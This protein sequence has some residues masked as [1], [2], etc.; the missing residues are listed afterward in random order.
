MRDM[1]SFPGQTRQEAHWHQ[2]WPGVVPNLLHTGG[3]SPTGILVY[4]GDLL[5]E[6]FRG[7]LIHCDAGPNVVRAYITTPSQHVARGI[8]NNDGDESALDKPGAG[9]KAESVDLI[10]AGDSWFRPSDACV[11]PDGAVYIADWYDPGVGGHATGDI[12]AKERD[13]HK[14][15]G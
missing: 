4:E 15:T 6:K 8:M 9:Y 10:K 12:G 2:R 5:P 1:S 11:A 13:W 14:L 7:A 3:G